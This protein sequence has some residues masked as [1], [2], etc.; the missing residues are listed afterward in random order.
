[1]T[2][3]KPPERGA[4]IRDCSVT[5]NTSANE[6]TRAAVEALARAAEEN[7]RAI[8][9]IARAMSPSAPITGIQLTNT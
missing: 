5:V 3:R 1:M 9:A 4:T 7:A 6:H 2:T 8:A